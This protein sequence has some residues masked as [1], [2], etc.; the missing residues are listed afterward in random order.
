[1]KRSKK[2]NKHLASEGQMLMGQSQSELFQLQIELSGLSAL[3]KNMGDCELTS[4]EL[5]GIGLSL[6]RIAERVSASLSGLSSLP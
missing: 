3:F 6:E 2:K 1:M 4:D 5:H